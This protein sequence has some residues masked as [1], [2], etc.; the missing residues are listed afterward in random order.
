M[1][2]TKKTQIGRQLSMNNERPMHFIICLEK[3][4][5]ATADNCRGKAKEAYVPFTDAEIQQRE[6][7]AIQAATAE[8]ER[9][10]EEDR[11]NA[12]KESARQKMVKGEPLTE[13]EASLIVI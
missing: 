4:D 13:E 9:K 11:I 12:L 6:L 8:A 2:G 7:D 3:H 5:H 10:A 1:Y